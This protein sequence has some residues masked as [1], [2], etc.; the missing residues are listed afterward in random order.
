VLAEAE[1]DW[2]QDALECM[3]DKNWSEAEQMKRL[4]KKKG[5]G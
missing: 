5:K 3:S 4:K 1:Y 2:Y